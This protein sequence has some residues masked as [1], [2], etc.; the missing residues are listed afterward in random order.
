MLPAMLRCLSSVPCRSFASASTSPQHV[1]GQG[2]IEHPAGVG[3]RDVAGDHLGN[4]HVVDAGA[5]DGRRSLSAER[6]ASASPRRRSPRPVTRRRR[7]ARGQLPARRDSDLDSR[8]LTKIRDVVLNGDGD[9]HGRSLRLVTFSTSLFFACPPESPALGCGGCRASVTLTCAAAASGPA[10]VDQ[11]G[12]CHRQ[13]DSGCSGRRE[14]VSEEDTA[15]KGRRRPGRSTRCRSCSVASRASRG[16][17]NGMP[18]SRRGG[19]R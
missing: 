7:A 13:G 6:Y 15:R 10:G 19:S 16:G 1:L 17:A 3:D 11:D 18:R 4:E 12:P 14:P 9:S 2:L 5:G 8:H